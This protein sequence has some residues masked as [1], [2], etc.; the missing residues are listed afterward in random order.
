MLSDVR[1]IRDILPAAGM[2]ASHPRATEKR[3]FR[4]QRSIADSVIWHRRRTA[5]YSIT[6]S[7]RASSVGGTVRPM[8][9]AVLKLIANWQ[10]WIYSPAV[11]IW[12]FLAQCLSAD[13]SCREAV[14]QL[15]AWRLARD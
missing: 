4:N 1:D 3:A 6:S 7:A 8:D 13:H 14:A 12:V 9:F 2:S 5:R 11:T 10:G 15:I